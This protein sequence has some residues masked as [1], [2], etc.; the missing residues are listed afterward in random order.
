MESLRFKS[1]HLNQ[2]KWSLQ[3]LKRSKEKFNQNINS[4]LCWSISNVIE[5]ITFLE[6]FYVSSPTFIAFTKFHWVHNVRTHFLYSFPL[7]IAELSRVELSWVY[8]NTKKLTDEKKGEIE[9]VFLT[10]QS[11]FLSAESEC[12]RRR[13][14]RKKKKKVKT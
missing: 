13:Q 14:K 7:L 8:R 4:S 10:Y 6:C 12:R 1:L 3:S 11:F 5:E 2:L 9:N